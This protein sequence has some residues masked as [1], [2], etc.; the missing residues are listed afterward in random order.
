MTP[1]SKPA[2][3]RYRP[4][5][6]QA[7]RYPSHPGRSKADRVKRVSHGHHCELLQIASGLRAVAL[8]EEGAVAT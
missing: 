6:Q 8:S 3:V 4:L 1:G 7:D 5:I 2:F